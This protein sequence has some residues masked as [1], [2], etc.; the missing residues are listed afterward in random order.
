MK[1]P[2][3]GLP[4]PNKPVVK[5]TD[6]AKNGDITLTNMCEQ[7]GTKFMD[8]VQ[9]NT[10]K[11]QSK[12]KNAGDLLVAYVSSIDHLFAILSN[13]KISLKP[14]CPG[15]GLTIKEFNK[16]GKFGCP[17]CYDHYAEEFD[18]LAVKLH[19]ITPG[20]KIEHVGKI[21]KNLHNVSPE[22]QLKTLK[23]KLAWAVEHEKFE[24]A[25]VLKKEI[26]AL[27]APKD[28]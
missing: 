24:E 25:A 15:C 19:D 26:E 2:F 8:E 9:N 22:D 7:C 28:H 16:E 17:A 11:E 23:L 27:N 20:A 12:K 14:P 13:K 1:C 21:P 10:A 18:S 6:I 5:V 4:C 3:T